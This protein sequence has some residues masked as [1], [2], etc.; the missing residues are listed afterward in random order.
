MAGF[1]KHHSFRGNSRVDP[2]DDETGEGGSMMKAAT[3]DCQRGIGQR[4]GT[5]CGICLS[6]IR[7]FPHSH[8][9]RPDVGPINTGLTALAS[10]VL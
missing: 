10:D 5:G 9:L 4:G 2:D 1:N 3:G 7:Y 8:G 6:A